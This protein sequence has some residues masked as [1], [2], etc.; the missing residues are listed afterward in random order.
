MPHTFPQG[1]DVIH[2]RFNRILAV[3]IWVISALLAAATLVNGTTVRLSDLAP[4]VLVALLAWEA[5]WRPF[6]QVDD[7]GVTLGNVLRT[8]TVPWAALVH[9]DTKFALTLY[10]PG[11][12]YA[13]WAAPAPGRGASNRAARAQGISRPRAP[14][15]GQPMVDLEAG[16][17]S[18]LGDQGS[19]PGD[20]P[21]TESG[22]A[23]YLVRSRWTAL[24]DAGR[25]E[26]G[27]ADTTKVTVE[28]HL[29][30]AIALVL[31]L[32]AT[33]IAIAIA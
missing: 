19:R 7:D 15:V 31:L 22:D 25:L 24:R 16:S 18:V 12:H 5:L 29:P 26:V 33:I 30:T 17:S 27:A 10:T 23:A 14:M 13:A 20:L 6:V 11:R 2:S 4:A 32:A 3:V 8:I 9:V 28:W 21:G 1:R